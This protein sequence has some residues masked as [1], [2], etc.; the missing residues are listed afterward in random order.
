[1]ASLIYEDKPKYDIW[2][3]AILG[4]PVLLTIIPALFL[5]NSDPETSISLLGTA[6]FIIVIYW[7]IMPRKYRIMDDKFKIALGGPFALN[8]SF[9]KIKTAREIKGMAAGINFVTSFKN[10]VEIVR[11]R[12]M[13]VNITPGDRELFL[14]N[15]DKAL[16]AWR[17]HNTE[18]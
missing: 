9:N 13:N 5:N 10:G 16:N 6:A 12:G 4:L 17:N 1:L 11:K 7:I 18:T 2:I 8:I 3:I 14:E 15:M